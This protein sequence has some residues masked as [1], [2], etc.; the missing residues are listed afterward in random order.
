M[1]VAETHVPDVWIE[2][3]GGVRAVCGDLQVLGEIVSP[4][5]IGYRLGGHLAAATA[6]AMRGLDGGFLRV[7]QKE[8]GTRQLLDGAVSRDAVRQVWCCASE[9]TACAA[10]VAAT[11]VPGGVPIVVVEDRKATGRFS[12]LRG[13][14]PLP[15]ARSQPLRDAVVRMT[16]QFTL[17]S[18][19]EAAFYWETLPAA[20]MYA[21]AVQAAGR[22]GRPAGVGHGGAYLGAVAAL[23]AAKAPIVVDPNDV[24]VPTLDG[25]G[26]L[27]DDFV[28]TGKSFAVSASAF[29]GAVTLVALY[30]RMALPGVQILELLP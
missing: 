4:G 13:F 16:G 3:A 6:S 19:R 22:P 10:A 23:A 28:T 29:R 1:T 21:V 7:R 8:H 26:L 15:P 17:S 5:A 9:V 20:H 24:V 18:G 30:S 25:P 2:H 14:E 27:L 11:A 12:P